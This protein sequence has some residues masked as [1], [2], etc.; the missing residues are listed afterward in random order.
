MRRVAELAAAGRREQLRHLLR[1]EIL[2]HGRVGRRADR[3]EDQQHLLL[4]DQPTHLLDGLGRAVTV[5]QTEQ[6]D[7][8]TVHA[9]LRVRLC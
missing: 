4:L 1:V 2:L 5:V 6:H 3:A 8:A 7:L 9:A